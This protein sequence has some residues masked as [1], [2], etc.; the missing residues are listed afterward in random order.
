LMC[1]Q[2][3]KRSLT[4]PPTSNNEQELFT[5]RLGREGT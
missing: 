5:R 3:D 1:S 4:T 2:C